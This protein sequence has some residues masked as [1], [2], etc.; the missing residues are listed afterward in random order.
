MSDGSRRVTRIS[1]ITGVSGEVLSMQDV[2][3][4]DKLGLG[5]DGRVRG[6][7]RSTGIIPK[8]S[9]RTRAAGFPLPSNFTEQVVEI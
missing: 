1:E 5:T 7:F 9:E 6:R 2:F 3:V 4:F 8:F